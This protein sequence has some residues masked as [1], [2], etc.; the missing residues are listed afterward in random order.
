MMWKKILIS[1]FILWAWSSM[2]ACQP[3]QDQ[4]NQLSTQIA[5][6]IFS[7][8]TAAALSASSITATVEPTNTVTPTQS[9]TA[10]QIAQIPE[11]HPVDLVVGLP[12]GTDGYPWWHDSVFYEIY[13]RS[14]YDS[15]GDGV[16]DLNGIIEKLDYLNDGDPETTDDLGITGIWLMPIFVSPTDHGYNVTD[17]YDVDPDYGSLSDLKALLN[18]AHE[19]GIRVI[20]DISLNV[21]SNQHPWFVQGT[22]PNSPYHDWYIWSNDDP[23]YSGSWGQQVWWPTNG[24]FFYSTFSSYSPDLNLENPAVKEELYNVVRFWLEDVG[25]DGFRLDSAKH[26][27]EEGP[28]QANSQSTHDWWKDFYQFYKQINP[29]AMTVGEVWED[30]LTTATYLQGDEFDLS[31]EFWLA[32]AMI[33]SVNGGNASRMNDQVLQSYTEIP[34]MRFGT[35]LTNHDQA[36]VMTQLF[37]S[38]QKAKLAA[39]LLLT[40]PGTPFIYYG[41]EIGL[42]GEW[43]NNWNRRPMQWTDSAFSGFST[44]TPLQPLG[45]GWENYNAALESQSSDSILSHYRTLIQIRNAHAALR[46]GDITVLTT[47]NEAIFSFLRIS[48]NEAVLVVVNLSDQPIENVWLTKSESSLLEGIYALAPILGEGDF[49]PVAVNQQGGLFHL[50][51]TL[52]IPPTSTFIFQLQ[53]ISP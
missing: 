48:A 29:Q 45:P 50:I 25:V 17:F 31:F 28:I 47:T 13:V 52:T 36:R 14:F 37:D 19:R 33:E 2:F 42:Q 41:E 34:E 43:Q 10:T 22:N 16:G 3:S 51:S 20:L 18:A 24:R 6:E 39:S 11:A 8:Q 23:G 26:L 21:T 27:I 15:D 35:F 38:D 44:A 32:G 46:V 53:K 49:A 5:D 4:I 9:T 30:T 40:A 7:T 1:L 12:Q